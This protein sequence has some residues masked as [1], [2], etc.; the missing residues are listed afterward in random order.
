MKTHIGLLVFILTTMTACTADDTP[1][2][3]MAGIIG[4][5]AAVFY[6]IA[7]PMVFLGREWRAR[8]ATFKP[9]HIIGVSIVAFFSANGLLL[10][11]D[12]DIAAIVFFL[13]VLCVVAC[14]LGFFL[15]SA[16]SAMAFLFLI[17]AFLWLICLFDI[18]RPNGLLSSLAKMFRSF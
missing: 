9:N 14:N 1:A 10:M 3:I 15:S 17:T 16:K 12:P 11:V 7:V 8:S 4:A 5:I 13:V 2:G 18:Y 6:G